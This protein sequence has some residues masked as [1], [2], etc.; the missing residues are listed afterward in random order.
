MYISRR[1]SEIIAEEVR[2]LLNG[3]VG[4]KPEREFLIK[5]FCIIPTG[6]VALH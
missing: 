2:Q 4:T 6:F 3:G 5:R 1:W